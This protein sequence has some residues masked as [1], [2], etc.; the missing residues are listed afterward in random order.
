MESNISERC[1]SG[2]LSAR[3][4]ALGSWATREEARKFWDHLVCDE[5][6]YFAQPL[7]VNGERPHEFAEKYIR[8]DLWFHIR[9][10]Q[11]ESG[12][13][14]NG[15]NEA[16]IEAVPF[17]EAFC[18]FRK[19]D[20]PVAAV[21]RDGSMFVEIPELIQL[22]QRFCL[23]SIRSVARLKR[24]EN[25]VEGVV[26]QSSL[27]PVSIVGSANRKNDSGGDLLGR[28]D[29]TRKQMDQIPCELVERGA[30]T[31]N[32]IP[33][34]ESDFLV[35]GSRSNYEKVQRSIRII[36]FDNRIRIAFNPVSH[37]LLSRLEVKV[38]P[39]GF[40]VDVLN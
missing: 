32:K 10:A 36:F 1:S 19:I 31:V 16:L 24:L 3:A 35:G 11:T 12:L 33:N 38:S 5:C 20:T 21:D 9:W 17:D 2:A 34:G 8:N 40:H 4:P 23:Q 15:Y 13:A 27:L 18:A 6:V 30:E 22:P 7:D 25:A 29:C 37:L 39:S 28:R 26:E 14:G